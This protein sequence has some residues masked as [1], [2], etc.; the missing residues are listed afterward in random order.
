MIIIPKSYFVVSGA[1]ED[2]IS[3]INSFDKALSDAGIANYNWVPVSSILPSNIVEDK[4]KTLPDE[5]SILFCVMSRVDGIRGEQIK[6]G[7]AVAEGIDENNKRFGFV[8]EGSSKEGQFE[9]RSLLVNKLEVMARIRNMKILKQNI[10]ESSV[11]KIKQKY[12]TAIA[13]VVFNSYSLR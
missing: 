8:V 6:A 2:E 3:H 1:G 5:G 9:L 13:V 12:G 10:L 7:I 4:T 11:L